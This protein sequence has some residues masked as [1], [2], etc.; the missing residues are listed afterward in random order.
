MTPSV[1]IGLPVYN[2]EDYLEKSIQSLLAQT[3]DDFELII[4]DNHSLDRTPEICEAHARADRRIRIVRNEKNLGAA[5]NYNRVFRESSGRFFKWASHD[6]LCAPEFLERCIDVLE[7]DSSV[8]LCY[9]RTSFIDGDGASLGLYEE[10]DDFTD[11]SP[12]SRFR[13]WLFGRSGPWCNAV[14]GV[15]RSDALRMTPLIGKYN[16]SDVILLAEILLRGRVVRIEDVLF[17]RRD[18]AGRSVRAHPDEEAR[19]V[20]FEPASAGKTHMTAWRWLRGY[21]S[22]VRR[23]PMSAAEKRRCGISLA[24]W[25]VGQRSRLKD[26]VARACVRKLR[27]SRP[28]AT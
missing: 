10:T 24:K 28:A 23:A 13:T 25:A 1:S 6:D 3:R 26:E 2:G 11:E 16:S 21:A 12:S 18:H 17:F 22:A 8:V 14:F 5:E 19:A 27:G 4:S 15:I 9:P 20:W 7:R